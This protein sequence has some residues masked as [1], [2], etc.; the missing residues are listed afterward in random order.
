M[1]KKK[2]PAEDVFE[3]FSAAFT[4]L[5]WW[6]PVLVTLVVF[7]VLHAVVPESLW[8]VPWFAASFFILTGVIGERTKRARRHLF[9]RNQ[10]IESIRALSWQ[11]FEELIAEA[12]RR[13]GYASTIT[14]G[15]ADGGI[16]VVLK[17]PNETVFVQCKHW[18]AFTVDV[19][20]ARELLGV[21]TASGATKGILITSGRF[22]AAA[23]QFA[24]VGKLELVDGDGLIELI[25]EIQQQVPVNATPHGPVP[26]QPT[27]VELGPSTA[28]DVP[29]CPKCDSK[30]ALRVARRGDHAGDRFWGC[31]RYPACRGTRPIEPKPT[32]G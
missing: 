4:K 19:M 3:T 12:Y 14:A 23:K 2:S 15:G 10:E 24:I 1:A 5:P 18:K 16:D 29:L 7:F 31:S 27:P 17:R 21:V 13:R 11:R 20:K 25:K 30:M 8:W 22:T 28:E 32:R 26:V 9:E 6:V